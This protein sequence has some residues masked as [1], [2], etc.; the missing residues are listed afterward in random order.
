MKTILKETFDSCE[1][2]MLLACFILKNNFSQ[3]YVVANMLTTCWVWIIKLRI[4]QVKA[5]GLRM[6]QA[7]NL[8]FKSLEH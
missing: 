4:V 3:Q 8:D 1:C 6:W 5:S 7:S 2:N